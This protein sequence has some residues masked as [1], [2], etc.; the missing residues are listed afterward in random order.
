MAGIRGVTLGCHSSLSSL[1]EVSWAQL[2]ETLMKGGS[3]LM[4]PMTCW[5]PL[6]T[7]LHYRELFTESGPFFILF[8]FFLAQ[9]SCV[10]LKIYNATFFILSTCFCTLSVC[11]LIVFLFIV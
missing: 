4:T 5:Q 11:R 6:L 2:Y 7:G 1:L 10:Y 9:M 8:L 3:H